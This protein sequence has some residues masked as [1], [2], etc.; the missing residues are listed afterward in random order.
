V[1]PR[2]ELTVAPEELQ[3]LLPDQDDGDDDAGLRCI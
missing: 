2:A 3:T 1:I